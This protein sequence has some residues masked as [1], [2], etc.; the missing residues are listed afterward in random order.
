MTSIIPQIAGQHKQIWELACPT[1]SDCCFAPVN[2]VGD[3]L[4]ACESCGKLCTEWD[5]EQFASR[6]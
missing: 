4:L 1:R 3:E 5:I 2:R 6:L